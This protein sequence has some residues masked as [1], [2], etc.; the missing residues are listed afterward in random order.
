MRRSGASI[1]LKDVCQSVEKD[2][3]RPR[4]ADTGAI[5]RQFLKAGIGNSQI[6]SEVLQRVSVITVN[7]QQRLGNEAVIKR[8]R[9]NA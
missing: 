6:G 3:L 9:F 1:A 5:T 4:S 8:L 2:F 7:S